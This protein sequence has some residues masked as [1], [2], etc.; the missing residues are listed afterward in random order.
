MKN[1]L[2]EKQNESHE[3]SEK[4]MFAIP[5]GVHSGV[6]KYWDKRGDKSAPFK[7]CFELTGGANCG[8]KAYMCFESELAL[9]RAIAP[10]LNGEDLNGVVGYRGKVTLGTLPQTPVEIK[11]TTYS[12]QSAPFFGSVVIQVGPVGSLIPSK[13]LI[14]GL[15]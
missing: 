1:L 15:N 5:Y 12:K 13:S 3:L 8:K 4:E 9:L 7:L 2:Q 14:S 10:C 6:L 11:V